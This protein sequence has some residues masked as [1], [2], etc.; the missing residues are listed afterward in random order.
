[1][2]YERN[3]YYYIFFTSGH[4][5]LKQIGDGEMIEVICKKKVW[6]PLLFTPN[7]EDKV[8]E[9]KTTVQ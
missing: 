9:Y 4:S 1:M 6:S 5:K 3:Y 7:V 2:I 8:T